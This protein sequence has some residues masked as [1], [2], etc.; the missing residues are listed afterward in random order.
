[1]NKRGKRG[2]EVSFGEILKV[3]PSS[4]S[5]PGFEMWLRWWDLSMGLEQVCVRVC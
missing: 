5:P 2:E 1:M 4:L 3:S